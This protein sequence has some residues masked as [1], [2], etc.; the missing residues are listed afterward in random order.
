ML[1]IDDED[2]PKNFIKADSS[3]PIEIIFRALDNGKKINYIMSLDKPNENFDFIVDEIFLQRPRG[4]KDFFLVI[5][6]IHSYDT[7]QN[8]RNLKKLFTKS[9]KRGCS[10]V[11][12]SQRGT[13]VDKVVFYQTTKFVFLNIAGEESYYDSMIFNGRENPAHKMQEMIDTAPYWFKWK[14]T[15]KN[16]SYC[17]YDLQKIDG[18]YHV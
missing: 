6:E 18:V 15:K 10:V 1:N 2:T 16:G 13:L 9:L 4:S 5:E 11:W 7:K 3:T 12:N 14:D 17:I 8:I